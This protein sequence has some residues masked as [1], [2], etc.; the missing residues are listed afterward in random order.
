[1]TANSPSLIFGIRHSAR[2]R[3]DVSYDGTE[4]S[5]WAVQPGRRTVQGVLQEALATVL[6]LPAVALTVAGR[7]DA[8]VHAT[9]QVAHCDLPAPARSARPG[10]P[11]RRRAAGRCRGAARVAVVRPPSTPGSR[12]CGGA[13]S[14]ASR[15]AASR[16][17]ADGSCWTTAA[18]L[19]VAAMAAA[20]SRWSACTTSPRSAGAATVRRP[21]AP[22]IDFDGR[23]GGRRDRLHHPGR[24]VLPLDG[25][26]ARRRAAG[27]RRGAPPASWPASLLARS[28]RAD[29]VTV[30][31][32][33]GL[34]LVEVGYPPD[35]ELAART[36]QTSARR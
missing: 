27:G 4:F 11:A 35:A 36:A 15:D 30:A 3:L 28:A 12:R 22:C 19:D 7:T 24:R 25:A 9:G 13:T 17:C 33:H 20:A 21:A 10:A 2:V 26:L 6:R 23:R 1:M 34:T 16:R 14:T 5:G 32:A 8:G 18:T 31:P 29:E